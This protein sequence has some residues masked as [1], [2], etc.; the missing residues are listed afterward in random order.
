MRY[1]VQCHACKAKRYY[2]GTTVGFCMRAAGDDGWKSTGFSTQRVCKGCVEH[3]VAGD[4]TQ[5]ECKN[6]VQ[7]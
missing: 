1:T 4:G 5:R 7:E 6:C 2:E 3:G